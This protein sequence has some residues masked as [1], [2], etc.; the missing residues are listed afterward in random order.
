MVVMPMAPIEAVDV[1]MFGSMSVP[2]RNGGER[3]NHLRDLVALSQPPGAV[4]KAFLTPAVA[5]VQCRC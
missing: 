1:P 3:V 5:S 2:G 4:R